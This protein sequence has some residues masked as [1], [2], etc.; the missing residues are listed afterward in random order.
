MEWK[1]IIHKLREQPEHG[2]TAIG[3]GHCHLTGGE[4]KIDLRKP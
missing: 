3:R 4:T 2:R 1:K